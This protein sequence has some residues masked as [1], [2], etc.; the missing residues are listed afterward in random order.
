[1]AETSRS[2]DATGRRAAA[3]RNRA[4]VVDAC[5]ELVLRDGYRATTIKAIARHAEVSPELIYKVFGG[6]KQVM[7]AVYDVA[8]AGDHDR[9]GVSD[10]PQLRQVIVAT[11]LPEKLDRYARFVLGVHQRLGGLITVLAEPD[12]DLAEIVATTDAERLIGVHAF[13]DHLVE[14]ALLPAGV[15]A[16]EAADACWLLTS[17]AVFVRLIEGRGWPT[18]RYLDWL[19]RMLT[20]NLLG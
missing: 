6:K 15:V 19:I 2:Y 16:G 17:P 4:A 14:Q 7:K 20:A 3:E 9:I 18:E 10:R 13:V 5:R 8:V 12:P 1:V 11:G